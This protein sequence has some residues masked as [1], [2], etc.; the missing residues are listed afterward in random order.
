MDRLNKF[1][2]SRSYNGEHAIRPEIIAGKLAAARNL[3]YS[4]L[5]DQIT[6][7][8]RLVELLWFLEYI[9]RQPGSLAPFIDGLVEKHPDRI[10]TPEMLKIGKPAGGRYSVSQ[11]HKI[12]Q[13][14]PSCLQ[15]EI[16][17]GEPKNWKSFLA[18]KDTYSIEPAEEDVQIAKW[19]A[20]LQAPDE[21]FTGSSPI[22]FYRICRAGAGAQIE[23]LIYSLCNETAKAFDPVPCFHDVY[24]AIFEAMDAWAA[25]KKKELAQTE[26]ARK[27]FDAL[28]YA[29]SERILVRIS[30][31]SRFGKTESIATYCAMYPG[32]IRLITVPCSNC[33]ADLFRAVADAFGIVYSLKT[34]FRSI[35][36]K[37]EFVLR[38]GQVGV[39]L[40]ES[41]FLLPIHF[42]ET[43]PPMRLNWVRTQIIDRGV[44]CILVST[45]QSYKQAVNKYLRK[46]GYAF[47]QFVGRNKFLV[48]LPTNLSHEDLMAVAR[49]H[50]PE[51][52]E[53][54]LELIAG[55]AMVSDSYLQAVENI[56]RRARFIAK[57]GGR[58]KI[59]IDDVDLAI[60]EVMPSY[61]PSQPKTARAKPVQP[62][63][64]SFAAPLQTAC[65]A[66]EKPGV[67][68]LAAGAGGLERFSRSMT[69]KTESDGKTSPIRDGVLV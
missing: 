54:Y 48:E 18:L 59:G 47:E 64:P 46:T 50:F 19:L 8:P 6:K 34:T 63:K 11:A 35:K 56:G 39:A 27:I 15:A 55:T 3:Q 20:A 57:R 9:W 49:V 30:G 25:E 62:L 12:W 42:S 23:S 10:G 60:S 53:D 66:V 67:S 43:T 2:Q 26:V 17:M 22:D 4:D 32:R 14:L 37:V 45:P 61:V 52:D 38:F 65:K 13:E 7:T 1:F 29:L 68:A 40:D 44:P 5:P 24:G 28:D 33:E 51:L 21:K 41:Q 31:D 16:E 36:E 58:D 69:P